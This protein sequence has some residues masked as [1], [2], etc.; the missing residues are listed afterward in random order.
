MAAAV[1]VDEDSPAQLREGALRARG[2]VAD[3]AARADRD[4]RS[5]VVPET[6][7]LTYRGYAVQDLAAH[8]SFEEVAYLLWY[9]ELPNPAQRE[10][11]YQPERAAR[12]ADRSLLSLL[13]K[14]PD[15]CHPMTWC[16]RRSATSARKT[17]RR[18]IIRRSRT[19]RRRCA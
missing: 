15:N 7:S 17:R 3:L 6:N 14:M 16:A 4:D 13:A 19:S 1:L 2:P 8:C 10:L 18:T 12:R 5:R 9:G 11:L